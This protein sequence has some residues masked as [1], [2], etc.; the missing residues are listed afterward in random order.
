MC[1]LKPGSTECIA[2]IKNTNVPNQENI[3][4]ATSRPSTSACTSFASASETKKTL[5][6]TA[7]LVEKKRQKNN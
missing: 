6:A 5:A 7:I 2:A 3:C 4:P 1:K